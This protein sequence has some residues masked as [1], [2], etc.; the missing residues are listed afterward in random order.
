MAQTVEIVAYNPAWPELYLQKA[1]RLKPLLGENLVALHHIGSTAVPGLAAKP[2]IDILAVVRSHTRLDAC[3][4]A[5]EGLGYQ[6][7]GEYGIPGRRYFRML[8]GEVHL[9]H[10]HAFEQGH[11]EIG[12][13][14]NFRD[15]LRAHPNDA[16][17]YEELKR[18]LADRYRHDLK[19][20]T[21]GKTDFIGELDWRA[22]DWQT[23]HQDRL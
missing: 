11:S 21:E 10:I 7:K 16:G 5:L 2:T 15:Y 9:F 23:R 1:T 3:N 12:R 4:P 17:A 18:S 19:G 6:P 8:D 22:A 14:L 13:H 20:Y